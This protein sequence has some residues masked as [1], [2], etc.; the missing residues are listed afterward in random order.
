MRFLAWFMLYGEVL[1]LILTPLVIGMERKPYRYT[2][3]IRV[4]IETA[5]AVPLVGRVLGWW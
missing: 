1:N 2:D 5:I 3:F 4:T